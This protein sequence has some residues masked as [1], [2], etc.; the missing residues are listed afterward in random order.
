M[1][2]QEELNK[3]KLNQTVTELI[4]RKNKN[5]AYR[6][7]STE[8]I[9]NGIQQSKEVMQSYF[10]KKGSRGIIEIMESMF[11]LCDEATFE[12]INKITGEQS[13]PI[14]IAYATLKATDGETNGNEN[15]TEL[16]ALIALN[17]FVSEK[18]NLHTETSVDQT[19]RFPLVPDMATGSVTVL[20]APVIEE[21]TEK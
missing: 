12:F 4:N 6:A 2:R 10:D 3:E 8:E 11:S 15:L 1:T 21:E 16:E 19:P 9:R 14:F 7:R 13:I 5:F 18:I 17:L 20:D